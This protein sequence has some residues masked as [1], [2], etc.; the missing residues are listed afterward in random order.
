MSVGTIEVLGGAVVVGNQIIWVSVLKRGIKEV[1]RPE[2][3]DI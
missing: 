1:C 2:G 3:S